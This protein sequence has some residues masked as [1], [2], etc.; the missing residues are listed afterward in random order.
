MSKLRLD[1]V[2]VERGLAASRERARA[3]VLAGQVRVDGQVIAKAGAAID[4]EAL[5]E[6]IAPD[7]PYASR[8]GL[9]LAHALEHLSEVAPA[10]TGETKR[11]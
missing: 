3:L 1:Q 9:K 10:S 4:A 7:H 5:V 2:V 6:L 11:L 8:G